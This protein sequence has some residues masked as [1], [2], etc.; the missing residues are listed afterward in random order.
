MRNVMKTAFH[1]EDLYGVDVLPFGEPAAKNDR[2][3]AFFRKAFTG[4]P[5][6]EGLRFRSEGNWY[7]IPK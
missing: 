6:E 4:E 3:R 5:A 2:L 1:L 7:E